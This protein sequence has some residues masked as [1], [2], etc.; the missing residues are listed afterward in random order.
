MIHKLTD[1]QFIYKRHV[2]FTPGYTAL[3]LLAFFA[4]SASPSSAFGGW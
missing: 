3:P 1:F 4:S 2:S